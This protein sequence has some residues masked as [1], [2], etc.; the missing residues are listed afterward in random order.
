[1]NHRWSISI[2]VHRTDDSI[3][4]HVFSEDARDI[5]HAKEVA[6]LIRVGIGCDKTVRY[7]LTSGLRREISKKA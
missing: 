7:T 6:A 4:E 1:M 5:D 2:E 3:T